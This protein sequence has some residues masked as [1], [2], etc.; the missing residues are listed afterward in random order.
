[1]EDSTLIQKVWCD[2]VVYTC[3]EFASEKATFTN[4]YLVLLIDLS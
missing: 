1:M 4:E 2:I 3:P